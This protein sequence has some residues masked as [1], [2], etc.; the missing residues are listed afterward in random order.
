MR[1]VERRLLSIS[2]RQ[3]V[4]LRLLRGNTERRA[5]DQN[6]EGE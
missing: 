1:A 5:G 6:G 2:R 3:V 4:L